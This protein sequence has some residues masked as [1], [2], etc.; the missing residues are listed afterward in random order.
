LFPPLQRP[1]CDC[2]PFGMRAS[3]W[4]VLEPNPHN[5]RLKFTGEV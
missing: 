4:P 1:S 3:L 2:I 5:C